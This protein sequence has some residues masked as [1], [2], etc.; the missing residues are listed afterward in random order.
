[1]ENIKDEFDE[2]FEAIMPAG[3]LKAMG[4]GTLKIKAVCPGCGYVMPSYPGRYS[5][6]PLCK[7][8]VVIKPPDPNQMGGDVVEIDDDAIDA[9]DDPTYKGTGKTVVDNLSDYDDDDDD[10]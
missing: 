3:I 9:T 8:T 7:E 6:C 1:M 5:K 10:D 2:L 4:R